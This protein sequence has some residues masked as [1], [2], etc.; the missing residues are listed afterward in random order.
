M[1]EDEAHEL[2][3]GSKREPNGWIRLGQRPGRVMRSL[4][5]MRIEQ[6]A[7]RWR[8]WDVL[9]VADVRPIYPTTHHD[10]LREAKAHCERIIHQEDEKR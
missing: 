6:T 4:S 3:P 1:T 9:R 10:T 7:N 8:S 5:F 2:L